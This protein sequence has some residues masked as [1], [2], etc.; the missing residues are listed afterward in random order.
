MT[1]KRRVEAGRRLRSAVNDKI[2]NG[3]A[4]VR[5]HIP[6]QDY[7]VGLDRLDDGGGGSGRLRKA[8][9]SGRRVRR[10]GENAVNNRGDSDEV[11]HGGGEAGGETCVESGA[12]ILESDIVLHDIGINR[13]AWDEMK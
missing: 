11:G 6:T 13:M 12:N 7:T 8:N 9:D 10:A 3:L 2:I 5:R 1:W 4:G